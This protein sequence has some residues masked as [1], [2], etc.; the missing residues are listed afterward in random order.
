MTD[1]THTILHSAKRFFSGTMLSRITGMLRDMSMAYVF[2]TQEAI[3]SF[4]VAFRFSHLLRRLFGEGA[5][6]SAFVPEFEALRLKNGGLAFRFFR[7]LAAL[8]TIFLSL[9][10]T[11]SCCG[12]AWILTS[13]SLSEGNREIVLLTLLMLPSLLFICLFGLNASLLQCEKSYFTPSVAP[14]AFNVIWIATVLLLQGVESEIAMKLLSGGVIV[15][16]FFQW[17]MTLPSVCRIL[18]KQLSL[19]LWGGICLY[20]KEILLLL[21]PLSLGIL[22]VAAAQVNSAIDAVFARYADAE[23]PA[24]LWY[25][26]RIQQ[27][28]LSLFAVAIGGAILPPLSRAIKAGDK[29]KYSH[30]IDYALR[31]S[32]TLLLPITAALLI[33]GDTCVSFLYGH[34]DFTASSIAGTTRCLWAYGAGLLPSALIL[35][36]APACYARGDYRAPAIASFAAMLL[37]GAL[38]AFFIMGLGLGAMSVAMATSISAWI[39]LAYLGQV[40]SRND[41]LMT[42]RSLGMHTVRIS[43]LTAAA[44]TTTVFA[45]ALMG[46]QGTLLSLFH[47]Q[48]PAF[49]RSFIDQASALAIQGG[50][51]VGTLLFTAWVMGFHTL[52]LTFSK[53]RSQEQ[54]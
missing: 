9:L 47:N 30:F 40:L 28:P 31:H 22:G 46:D 52:G 26:L 53:I 18:K 23:G 51:F 39:N 25:A 35:I 20:S 12:L 8:L 48:I 45:R 29:S 7:D 38:N 21:A 43:I 49:S 13:M 16:C 15:A 37:N 4:M 44:V 10:I 54:N 3:A 24:L 2:G 32:I 42:S 50:C 33:L 11:V 36:L 27:L 1:T 34:G 6:Q 14:V 19:P 41:V 17:A 5:L